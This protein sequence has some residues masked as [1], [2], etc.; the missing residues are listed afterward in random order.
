MSAGVDPRGGAGT[1]AEGSEGSD[2][3][4]EHA[5]WPALPEPC[6]LLLSLAPSHQGES[7][8]SSPVV[9]VVVCFG[10]CG[11]RRCILGT[12]FSFKN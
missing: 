4:T 7:C 9:E 2:A 5:Q 8:I 10:H 3:F 1:G 12:Y 6:F 11:G